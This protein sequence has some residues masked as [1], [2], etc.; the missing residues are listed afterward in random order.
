MQIRTTK[1][2]KQYARVVLE[3]LGASMEINFSA[4]NFEKFSGFLAKDNIVLVKVRPGYE[5]ELRFSAMDVEMLSVERGNED[6]RLALRPEDLT[7]SSIATLRE[8]LA[9]YPGRSPVIVETGSA[10]KG[11]QTRPGVQREHRERRRRSAHRIRSKRHKGLVGRTVVV[12]SRRMYSYG[13]DRL[14]EGHHRPQ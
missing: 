14:Y 7:Q 12:K 8:I 10:G 5:E 6:L 11:L 13:N 4:N 3:D 9:R 2:G 1:M